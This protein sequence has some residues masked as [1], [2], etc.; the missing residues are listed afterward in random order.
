MCNYLYLKTVLSNWSLTWTDLCPFCKNHPIW[1]ESIFC[2]SQNCADKHGTLV[3]FRDCV[4]SNT[5]DLMESER[6]VV[7]PNNCTHDGEPILKGERNLVTIIIVFMKS[8][9]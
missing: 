9:F 6:V 8:A 3:L 2:T 4:S 7:H 1:R 5:S